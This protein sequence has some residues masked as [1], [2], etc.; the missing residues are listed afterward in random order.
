MKLL[1][2][3]LLFSPFIYSELF[4]LLDGN[5][6]QGDI[7]SNTETD[8][9]IQRFDNEGIISIPWTELLPK[10]R[11]QIQNK[12]GI[13]ENK[14]INDTTQ[15]VKIYLHT[16][17]MIQGI[18]IQ[19]KAPGIVKVRNRNG[20]KVISKSNIL[21]ETIEQIP[22]TEIYK[23]KDLYT[24]LKKLYKPKSAEEELEFSTKLIQANLL[25]AAK[26]HLEKAKQDPKL[27]EQIEAQYKSIDYL[28]Q[29]QQQQAKRSQ[30]L[31]YR[32]GHHFAKALKT[33]QDLKNSISDQEYQKLYN[34]T[35]KKEKEYYTAEIT[36]LWMNKVIDKIR[37]IAS[38]SFNEAQ[39]YVLKKLDE[40]VVE[41]LAKENE[42]PTTTV[43]EYFQ[44]RKNKKSYRFNYSTGTF[45]VGLGNAEPSDYK[46]PNIPKKNDKQMKDTEW[47]DS[48]SATIKKDWL[49]A[50]YAENKLTVVKEEVKPCPAC[51]ASGV[52]SKKRCQTC[53]G[54]CY[55]RT[56]V[57]K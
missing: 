3:F 43:I 15:G 36:E 34:E 35:V 24:E 23:D 30:F 45:L 14:P 44:E 31:K 37:K 1:F 11:Q 4:Y 18:K 6:L 8:V 21:V 33:L 57:A 46:Q 12:V 27:L 28:K 22:L 38:K 54:I 39:E 49:K 42:L 17:D 5:I 25:E 40:E 29:K 19:S 20:E 52:Q 10:N 7:L 55:Q 41:E 56:I 13:I 26:K 9:T 53:Q 50:L 48:V 16:G 32:S 51:N 2:F 47:W